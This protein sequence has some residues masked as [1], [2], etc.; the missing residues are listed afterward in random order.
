[1]PLRRVS[2]PA[3]VSRALVGRL[4]E[5]HARA[6]QLHGLDDPDL[7]LAWSE[8]TARALIGADEVRATRA[9]TVEDRG[10]LDPPQTKHTV[11][12]L[13]AEAGRIELARFDGAPLSEEDR[14]LLEI[15][16]DAAGLALSAALATSSRL[17]G[18][19]VVHLLGM[20]TKGY[21][22]LDTDFRV[23][24][25]N[26]VALAL[27]GFRLEDAVGR[28]L[29]DLVPALADIAI[30]PPAVPIAEQP[31]WISFSGE[32][33][34]QLEMQI[35]PTHDGFAVL[36]RDVTRERETEERLRASQKLEAVGQLTGGIAHDVNNML[37]VMLGNLDELFSRRGVQASRGSDDEMA[38]IGAAL[39]A[40]ESAAELV[41][42]LVA[43]ARLQPLSP[44]VIDIAGLLASLEGLLRRTLGEQIT[45]R[46]ACAEDLWRALVDPSE[47][48]S[49]ILN[50]ALNAKDAMPRGG[51]LEIA[52]GNLEVDRVY[53][54]LAGL[55]RTGEYVVISVADTGEGM[56][57]EV[58]SRAF[59]P[60][61]TTKE[62]GKGT[63]L[64]L[65][66]VYGLARQSGG[67]AA[68][69]SEPGAGTIVRIYL[70][71]STAPLEP[72]E[73]PVRATQ[74]G[75]NE[76]ILLVEDNKLVREHTEAMLKA[77][78]YRVVAASDGRDAA[79][80]LHGGLR[81][82]LLVTDVVLP[83]GM[84]G[85]DV[86][87]VC[88]GIVP[89]IRVLFMSGYAGDVLLQNGRLPPGIALLNKPFR[90]RELASVV[91]EQLA[92]PPWAATAPPPRRNS[93]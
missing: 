76:T 89:G 85:R 73:A 2:P 20:L 41:A 28:K 30:P 74:P 63:G 81:P 60:F 68:I 66:M 46:F 57:R 18:L 48:Q 27:L 45:L 55:A 59:D 12:A 64:G 90:R 93:M 39:Q 56:T 69:D 19:D 75:G 37:T 14:C 10:R 42:H 92:G 6:R 50:L 25:I 67:A 15:V 58:S 88:A 13:G 5:F 61:F 29:R 32:S 34:A 40:G 35:A 71:R 9:G 52:A 22:I 36:F 78:G 54:R 79:E 1:M 7:I 24:T 84:T 31:A 65:S 70:P 4:W 82:E 43:F 21:C 83:A 16:A 8:A 17:D 87:D 47:L 86:A 3:P 62:P 51:E 44:R 33:G 11:V 23:R 26:D 38:M 72:R 91:R 77:L 53:A 49:A 80:A